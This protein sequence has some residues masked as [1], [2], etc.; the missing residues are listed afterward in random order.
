[1]YVHALRGDTAHATKLVVWGQSLGAGVATFVAGHAA[2]QSIR[3]DGLILETPFVSVKEMLV[4]LYPQRWLPYFYLSPFLWNHW[5]SEVG[6]ERI[7]QGDFKPA[8][9]VLS[10]DKDELVPLAHANRLADL[11]LINGCEVLHSKV[12]G[13]LHTEA[14]LKLQGQL[15]VTRFIAKIL[16]RSR[17]PNLM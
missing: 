15:A 8:V 7:G 1:M 5:D 10:A 16:A 2:K 4:T 17:S 12:A 6:L 13:A 14:L 11:C 3:I 9:L